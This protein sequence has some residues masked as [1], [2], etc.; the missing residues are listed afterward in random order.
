VSTVGD[1]LGARP[2]ASATTGAPEHRKQQ[3]PASHGGWRRRFTREFV[4]I[5]WM[6][7][8]YVATRILCL[9]VSIFEANIPGRWTMWGQL[10]NWDG[11]WY[12]RILT[13]VPP[14]IG[15]GYPT[16]VTH[17]QSTLGF[18]PLYSMLMW[19]VAH[20]WSTHPWENLYIVAGLIISFFTGASA[21]VLIGKLTESW[22]GRAA[23]RRCVIFLC[24]WPGSVVF[25]MVY[26][27]GVLLTLVAGSLLAMQKR[28]WLT[29]GVCAAF[30]TAVGPIAF[31]I[32]PACAIGA[33]LELRDR[34][35]RIGDAYRA[36]IAPLLAPLGALGFGLFLW[37][38]VGTPFASFIAQH[39]GWH[40]SSSPL[41][42]WH[43]GNWLAH[44]ISTSP[45]FWHITFNSNYLAGLLGA[46]IYVAGLILLIRGPRIPL[47][48]MV[49]V[50][51][52]M[53][54][55]FTSQQTPPNQRLLLCAFP[56]LLVFAQ[57]IRGR[58]FAGLMVFMAIA[59]TLM[60]YITYVGVDLR[61]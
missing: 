30:A 39:D 42:L 2:D 19:L 5:R 58:W 10:S 23:G 9:A 22:W 32:I 50:L 55:T 40:E 61:P 59:L 24:L 52:L 28:R 41:A 4:A 17:Y 27:E 33:L 20:V 56:V 11:V 3:S 8:V 44:Q 46:V 53:L 18:F 7:G 51:G 26:S 16:F 60:D 21:T 14:V 25:S 45:N 29:A 38:R 49:W 47:P 35:W 12:L 34:G 15:S 31:P 54:L 36:F 13:Q 6:L 57:R 48:S 43:I 37:I 1:V